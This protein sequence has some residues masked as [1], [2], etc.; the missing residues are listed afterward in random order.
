MSKKIKNIFFLISFVSFIFFLTKYYFSEKNLILTNK[1]RSSYS[2]ALKKYE[3]NLPLLENN[4]NNII[5]YIDDLE[6]FKNKRK[7]RI[8]ENLISNQNE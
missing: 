2:L 8:W 1:S 7:K 3:D 5:T 4:T 6:E